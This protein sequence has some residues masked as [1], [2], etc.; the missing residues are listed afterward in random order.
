MAYNRVSFIVVCGL[1][2]TLV[3]SDVSAFEW[4]FPGFH[5]ITLPSW[6]DQLQSIWD[7][8]WEQHKDRIS[9]CTG[10]STSAVTQLLKDSFPLPLPAG[11]SDDLICANPAV[12][13]AHLCGP[14][15][16]MVYMKFL[17]LT[18]NIEKIPS[19]AFCEVGSEAPA[20]APG[21]FQT[22][23]LS[24]TLQDP[25]A[26]APVKPHAC[27]PGYFCPGMLACMLP[28]PLGAYCP[29]AWAA[30]PPASYTEHNLEISKQ[31]LH[32]TDKWCA[33]Y[34]YKMRPALGCG[35]A[36]KWT[37]QPSGAFPTEGWYAGSGSLYCEGGS[38]CPDPT[39]KLPCKEGYYCKQGSSKMTACPPLVSCP[40]G[41]EAP[42]DNWLGLVLD[43]CMFLL[44]GLLWHI[45]QVYNRLMRRLSNRE[46]VRIMWHKTHPEVTIV[47]VADARQLDWQHP[48]HP[49]AAELASNTAPEP[50]TAPQAVP[51]PRASP[52]TR[53]AF[54]RSFTRRRSQGGG[55]Q[56]TAAAVGPV[57]ASIE[58]REGSQRS[59][60]LEFEMLSEERR[61]STH[62]G[63]QQHSR[64]LSGIPLVE[65]TTFTLPP[66]NLQSQKT[67][68]THS[69][70]HNSDSDG[71]LVLAGNYQIATAE[72]QEGAARMRDTADGRVILGIT[73]CYKPVM[74]VGFQGLS[75]KL[76]SC[77]K[78]VLQNVTGQLL[79]G[80]L[81]A[82]M[83]PSGEYILW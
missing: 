25:T 51:V 33:P 81:T 77:G 63:Q 76:K 80:R 2:L 61:S 52:P 46:R 71:D 82:I 22:L 53:L 55:G 26:T 49:P 75:M 79:H 65:N 60:L 50:V 67:K 73:G 78:Q 12:I 1:H 15:E 20:C 35:G 44:L 59:P 57:W 13:S 28:C 38:Y 48:P 9:F 70:S 68:A 45:S 54:L 31:L 21:F 56:A 64:S 19:N 30:D 27:C 23:N 34:A 8:A 40:T 43:G 58:G 83:G 37:I 5:N 6:P 29:R 62:P 4:S 16:A 24:H 32:K 36:D 18:D 74:D 39:T 17:L 10:G 11:P 41:T 66:V 14:Q 42:T 47:Q 69:A 3:S 72:Q 7:Q